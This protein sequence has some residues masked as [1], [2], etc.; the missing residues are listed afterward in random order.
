MGVLQGLAALGRSRTSLLVLGRGG[1]RGK[2]RSRGGE[3]DG[4]FRERFGNWVDAMVVVV[5]AADGGQAGRTELRRPGDISCLPPRLCC[6]SP[7]PL[8]PLL[9]CTLEGSLYGARKKAREG[10]CVCVCVCVFTFL[11]I[12]L[13]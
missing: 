12:Y 10:V 7:P 3:G 13:T 4:S 9:Y 1:G 11:Y 5:M 2:G 8:P 6:S